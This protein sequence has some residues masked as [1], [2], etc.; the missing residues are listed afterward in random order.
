MKKRGLGRDLSA[1]L[2]SSAKKQTAVSGE[3]TQVSQTTEG[4]KKLPVEQ[5][6]RGRYQPRTEFHEEQLQELADSIGKQ[7]I[8]QP[9]IVRSISVDPAKPKYEIIAGERRWRAAQ[10]ASLH[11]VPVVIKK[12]T[13]EEAIAVS[14]IENI[15]REDL[16]PIEEASSLDRL[17]Q[18]FGLTHQE[19]AD[20]VGRSRAAVSNLL[21]LLSLD[22][23]V[24]EM[25]AHGDIEMGHARA[26]LSLETTLQP[27]VANLVISKGLSVREIEAHVRKILNPTSKKE[28]TS[29]N[30]SEDLHISDLQNRLSE[31]LGAKVTCQHSAKGKGKLVI[32]YNSLDELDGILE[33]IK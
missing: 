14:L 7:G 28:N 33:H 9:I 30:T 10:L 16:N 8:I 26:L 32:Q 12:Y 3:Q 20:A 17:I 2:G 6:V 5:M 13:D 23:G 18:E 31:T 29:V 19:A 4:L 27:S 11:E 24:K 15:Q 22:V 1:L 21:R 25:L